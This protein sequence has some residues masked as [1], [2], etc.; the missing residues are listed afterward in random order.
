M[1]SIGKPVI[2]INSQMQTQGAKIGLYLT[3]VISIFFKGQK[4]VHTCK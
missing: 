1:G 4:F 2:F 3:N